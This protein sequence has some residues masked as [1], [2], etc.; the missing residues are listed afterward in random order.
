MSTS[1]PADDEEKTEEPVVV[2]SYCG[3]W[4]VVYQYCKKGMGYWRIYGRNH[5]LR[6]LGC[7]VHPQPSPVT[8]WLRGCTTCI[9][10]VEHMILVHGALVLHLTCTRSSRI[11]KPWTV[12]THTFLWT[13]EEEETPWKWLTIVWSSL[14]V[15]FRSLGSVQVFR[16]GKN[17]WRRKKKLKFYL[18]LM[19]T[20]LVVMSW[21][22]YIVLNSSLEYYVLLRGSTQVMTTSVVLILNS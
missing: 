2:V 3:G 16:T 20:T 18:D 8:L 10:F 15:S 17:K 21:I 19:S 14:E 12:W 6:F 5:I 22:E 9:P 4:K 13:S 7:P 11:Q 1:T